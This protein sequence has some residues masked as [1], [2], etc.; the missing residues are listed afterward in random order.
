MSLLAVENLH[1]EIGGQHLVRGVD[2]AVAR[3]ECLALVGESGSGKSLTALSLM[4]LLPANAVIRHDSWQF[5]GESLVGKSER[6]WRGLRASRI[7]M[8][9]QNPMTALNPTARVGAQI[10]EVLRLHTACSR[11][12][13]GIRAVEL[14]ERLGI[15]NAA[16]RARQYPFEMSGG[17]LQ[18]AV[19]AMAVACEPDL[20]IADEPTTALDV[21]V[22]AEVLVLLR[23]LCREKNVGLLL[24]THD[25][26]VVEAMAERVAVMYAGRIVETGCCQEVLAA[27][28]HPYTRSLKQ[29]MPR[30]GNEQDA[31]MAIPGTPPDLSRTIPGCAFAARCPEAMNICAKQLPPDYAI[32]QTQSCE[33]WLWEEHR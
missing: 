1:I 6:D 19:I 9:F 28:G 11:R 4:N 30:L 32:T 31:L 24:I 10:A 17:M 23:E 14:L 25:F 3:G 20:L 18:R 2:L 7:G 5:D 26:G 27:P 33:C 21:T 13:A 8:V 12:Q 15:I 22:Q 16:Q 29:A